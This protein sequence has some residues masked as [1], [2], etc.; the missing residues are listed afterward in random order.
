MAC[1]ARP[2]VTQVSSQL[3][4]LFPRL[5]VLVTLFLLLPDLYILCRGEPAEAIAVLIVMRLAIALVTGNLLV[6]AARAVGHAGSP[7][8]PRS[9]GPGCRSL[10][11]AAGVIV[12]R[13]ASVPLTTPALWLTGAE[14]GLL[15]AGLSIA[16]GGLAGLAGRG[17]ARQYLAREDSPPGPAPLL[18]P[19]ALRGSL[20]GLVASAALL[21]T[22]L[23]DPSAAAS[24]PPARGL[25]TRTCRSPAQLRAARLCRHDVLDVRG[26]RACRGPARHTSACWACASVWWL[27]EGHGR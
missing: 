1:A 8:P 9:P 25:G 10:W 20:A 26:R 23:A 24:C 12:M 16:L 17:L 27:S 7:P 14:R 19:W 15:L 13:V 21:V 3:R 11:P 22:A 6:H 18:P 5:P 4:W 2:V